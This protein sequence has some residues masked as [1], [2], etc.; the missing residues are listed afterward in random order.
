MASPT[1]EQLLSLCSLEEVKD[2][3]DVIIRLL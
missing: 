2:E 3:E 1:L